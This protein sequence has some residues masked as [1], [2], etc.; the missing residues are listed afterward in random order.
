VVFT[1]LL[2][3]A[4]LAVQWLIGPRM[5][6]LGSRMLGMLGDHY[7]VALSADA[8]QAELLGGLPVVQIRG[9]S[10]VDPA[11]SPQLQIGFL[12]ARLAL[13]PLLAGEVR[14][15][16]LRLENVLLRARRLA[17]RHLHI[18]G[19]TIDP[20]A[21]GAPRWLEG[22]LALPRLSVRNLNLSWHDEILNSE[23]QLESL[24]VEAE[25]GFR[26]HR[27]R[28]D[29]V[30][31]G[32]IFENASLVAHF[33]HGLLKSAA[34][35]RHWAGSVF[36]GA[37]RL[38]LAEAQALL[39]EEMPSHFPREGVLQIAS[40]IDFSQARISGAQLR[41]QGQALRLPVSEGEIQLAHLRAALQAQ[42]VFAPA[43]PAQAGPDQAG[44][45][46][47]DL[48]HAGLGQR[49]FSQAGPAQALQSISLLLSE[50]EVE[51]AGGVRLAVEGKE[52]RLRVGPDGSLLEGQLVLAPLSAGGALGF[53]KRLPLPG[54]LRQ[55]LA[56]LE[57]EGE[58]RQVNLRFEDRKALGSGQGTAYSATLAVER[59]GVL[60]RSAETDRRA[61]PSFRGLSGTLRIS[62]EGGDMELAASEVAS[63]RFPGVFE[64]PD[65]AV[66]KATARL[67]W[68]YP[69]ADQAGSVP[70]PGLNVEIEQLEFSNADGLAQVR[71]TYRTGG[72]GAGLVDLQGQLR[73]LRADR[74][75]R[76]LPLVVGTELRK[77]LRASV[78][79]G[80]VSQARFV[81]RGD[82]EDFPFSAQGSGQFL[83]EGQLAGSR[84]D[85][86]PGWPAIE[87]IVGTLHFE[88]AAMRIEV[89]SGQS[90][91][92]RLENTRAAIAELDAPVLRVGG[93]AR[94]KTGDMIRFVNRSPIATRLSQFSE[95]MDARGEAQLDLALVLPLE[96]LDRTQVL[97]T[98]RLE[99]NEIRLGGDL[100]P[101]LEVR[102]DFGFTESAL[103]LSSLRGQ[104]LGGEVQLA[105]RSEA[106]GQMRL[107]ASGRATGSALRD[108]LGHPVFEKVRGSLA[109]KAALTLN[110]REVELRADSDGKGLLVDL[111]EPLRKSVTEAWP[112]RVDLVPGRRFPLNSTPGNDGERRQGTIVPREDQIRVQLREQLQVWVGRERMQQQSDLEVVSGVIAVGTEPLLPARGLAITVRHPLVEV[113]SWLPL[114]R[115]SDTQPG[116]LVP[117]RLAIATGRL[118]YD[119]RDLHDA[120]IG[121][122][123]HQGRWQLNLEAREASGFASFRLPSADDP[124]E[125]QAR[126]ARIEL[127]V[128]ES[129]DPGTASDASLR[130][131]PTMDVQVARL[132]LGERELGAWVVRA[133]SVRHAEAWRWQL[134]ELQMQ[135]DGARLVA[136]GGWGE[137]RSGESAIGKTLPA[138]QQPARRSQAQM[139]QAPPARPEPT[140]GPLQQ[141]SKTR[142]DFDLRIEDA[143]RTLDRL[144]F[145][146]SFTGG[147]GR[148]GGTLS[149]QGLPWNPHYPTLEGKVEASLGRGRFLRTE[150]GVAKLLSV[151]NLQAL[152][153]RL[154]FDFS[155]IFAR[156]YSFDGLRADARIAQGVARTDNFSMV[157]PQAVVGL[158]GA[159]DLMGETQDVL[160]E[161]VPNLDAG[162]ASIAYGALINPFVGLGSLVA[163]YALA[164]PLRRML[165][166][167]Y[168]ITGPWDDPKVADLGRAGLLEVLQGKSDDPSVKRR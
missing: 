75:V 101:L 144:G 63:L 140:P 149:W 137:A 108:W 53:A 28:V 102:G 18:A 77:W 153:R 5:N 34:D 154:S 87:N 107:E 49:G 1:A 99:N 168:A 111:P 94:G 38:D 159:V 66:D 74:V 120:V 33:Q 37:R 88:A 132:K 151:L 105:G 162:M 130:R 58:L 56:R 106:S 54:D 17:D 127:P 78:Q 117:E 19:L 22:A 43:R 125:L 64:D 50:L 52:H 83:V 110:G 23:M 114:L 156:G 40:W 51:E 73:E 134:D 44:P 27:W 141:P 89:R 14:I 80:T 35:W 133:S 31:A 82:I 84:L 121:A 13:I 126:F 72:K 157:G 161:I 4:Y 59:I 164:D 41:L 29:L 24:S 123:Q 6:D 97:G 166:Y 113:E 30:K 45:A 67:R 119:G 81:L 158:R 7:G 145:P 142:V 95:D 118:R 48:A 62:E 20:A 93:L 90:M 12:E 122:S 115:G 138:L 26:E 69:R 155:D 68:R 124:G 46:Q 60:V 163:Q 131:L 2:A 152:P 103:S 96:D 10:L 92:L 21:E 135:M 139:V 98:V 70:G 85:Y 116:F 128:R 61:L 25:N 160:A 86:A 11:Q 148:I 112:I 147:E 129:E 9:L 65:F 71:G 146:G 79:G 76:Y 55:A 150:P 39:D 57:V 136:S 91:G 47:A 100:P 109:Y 167:R 165:T 3:S 104:F 36:V 143:G 32:G 16:G 15:D 8:V 42:P